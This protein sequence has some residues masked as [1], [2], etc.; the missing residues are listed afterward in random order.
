M[1]TI[2]IKYKRIAV[3][4]L[5]ILF[6]RG[7]SVGQ[8]CSL[9]CLHFIAKSLASIKKMTTRSLILAFIISGTVLNSVGQVVGGKIKI[10]ARNLDGQS[11]SKLNVKLLK[12]SQLI[13]LDSTSSGL[14]LFGNLPPDTYELR[15]TFENGQNFTVSNIIVSDSMTKLIN[16][17][18]DYP[19]RFFEKTKCPI[20]DMK[21]HKPLAVERAVYYGEDSLYFKKQKGQIFYYN[22]ALK[23]AC[24][25]DTYCTTH[26]TFY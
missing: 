23:D 4:Q 8:L 17:K 25:P 22:S 21:K 14:L 19:C 13:Q 11:I 20:E 7:L 5:L 9:Y 15:I 6:F 18:V 24:Y 1:P 2:P 10:G 12:D 26:K 16:P 3:N